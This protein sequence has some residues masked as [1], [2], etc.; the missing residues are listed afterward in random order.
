MGLSTVRGAPSC[1]ATPQRTHRIDA[2]ARLE[3]SWKPARNFQIFRRAD[4]PILP[5]GSFRGTHRALAPIAARRLV[6]ASRALT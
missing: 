6:C 1:H 5:A 3:V 4:A 2:I